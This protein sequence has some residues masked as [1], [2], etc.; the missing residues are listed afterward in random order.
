MKTQK[1]VGLEKPFGAEVLPVES[2]L[3]RRQ[4]GASFIIIALFSTS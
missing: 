4:D 1:P 2:V 3:E